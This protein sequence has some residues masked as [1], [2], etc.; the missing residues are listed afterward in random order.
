MQNTYH[1]SP[2]NVKKMLSDHP[3]QRFIARMRQEA[4]SVKYFALKNINSIYNNE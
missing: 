3:A 4:L 2:H 1:L